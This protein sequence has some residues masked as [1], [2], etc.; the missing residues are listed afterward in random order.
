MAGTAAL[1]AEL[2]LATAKSFLATSVSSFSLRKMLRLV[3]RL[4]D[5]RL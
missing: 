3:T 2:E 5:L 1:S 4:R